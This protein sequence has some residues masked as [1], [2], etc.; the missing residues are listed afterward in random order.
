[1]RGVGEATAAV[2]VVNAL[3]TGIGAALGVELRA[4]AEVTVRS[5]DA[6]A[7]RIVPDSARTP[8]AAAMLEEGMRWFHP[9]SGLA[10]D[11]ALTSAIPPSVGLKS[12]SAV[13]SAI[14]LATAR[15]AGASV[16]PLDIAA[17]GADVAQRIG[18][19]ATGAFDDA[20]A[21]LVR[22]VVIT[23]NRQ[24]RV[25]RRSSV[26]S[27][28]G[29]TIWIP[30]GAHPPSPSVAGRFSPPSA[31]AE[32]ATDAA[33]AG[34]WEEAM[35]LNS[36]LVEH[37][38]GYR[39]GELRAEARR[40]GAVAVGVSGLGPALAAVAPRA[41]VGGVLDG[42]GTTGGRQLVVGLPLGSTDDL[43]GVL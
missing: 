39:Y 31:L 30:E 28:I 25:L 6:G 12:S 9:S 18:L 37:H 4:R 8:L 7:A 35:E 24:R 38:M 14:L 1:M 27:G 26:S 40:R 20:L 5:G 32:R 15:S 3:S 41:V 2:S 22:G 13:G 11:L 43:G 36:E 33:L 10:A 21:G 42:L 16:S 17:R 23:D 29:V 34:A 19:S